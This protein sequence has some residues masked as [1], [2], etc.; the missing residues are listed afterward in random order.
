MRLGH[1]EVWIGPGAPLSRH[2][3]RDDTGQVSLQCE[4]LQVKHQLDV[5]FPL[6]GHAGRTFER[7]Q[8]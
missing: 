1:A 2:L 6:L 4:H 8:W 5:V 3:E 7:H